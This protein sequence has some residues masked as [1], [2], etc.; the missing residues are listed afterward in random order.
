VLDCQRPDVTLV[1]VLAAVMVAVAPTHA[2]LP[3]EEAVAVAPTHAVLPREAAPRVA[4][5][6]GW[7]RNRRGSR[8]RRVSALEPSPAIAL[9]DCHPLVV[10]NCFRR[11]D[12]GA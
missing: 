11:A 10:L 4:I 1:V 9:E 7:A 2:V 8:E 6:H 5:E 12:P 3:R